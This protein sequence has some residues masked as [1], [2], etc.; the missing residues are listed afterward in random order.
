MRHLHALPGCFASS[1][2]QAAVSAAH[3][4]I[5]SL[6]WVGSL[7]WRGYPSRVG[8]IMYQVAI[9]CRIGGF[10]CRVGGQGQVWKELSAADCLLL[11]GRGSHACTQDEETDALRFRLRQDSS[12]LAAIYA[13]H[14]AYPFAHAPSCT[15]SCAAVPLASLR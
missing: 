11:W 3:L 1:S 8:A 10:R 4:H 9:D 15:G 2:Q 14:P 7:G 5:P 6:G 13:P 12:T